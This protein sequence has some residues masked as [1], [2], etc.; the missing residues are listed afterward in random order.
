MSPDD[1]TDVEHVDDDVLT[2]LALGEPAGTPD[3]RAHVAACARCTQEVDALAEVAALARASE[4][5]VAPGPQVWDAIARDL[6]LTDRT[7]PLDEAPSG[8]PPVAEA[9]AEAPVAAVTPLRPRPNR[10]TWAFVAG[11]AAAGLVIGGTG[12]WAATRT[13]APEVLASATLEPLPGWD[14][15][16]K[17]FV[18]T[19]DGHRVL[20][21][22]LE[23]D[24]GSAGFRE[25]WLLRPDV[26]GLVS[27]GTLAGS[28]G[29][30]D[31]PAGLDLDEFSVV[32]VSEEQFDG[33]PAHSGDSIVRGPL[34]A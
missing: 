5:L 3:E 7:S 27:L 14:A 2:L 8:A 28:T 16:G 25:V 9:T 13:A 15:S 31:L 20:V 21:V 12:V 19:S 6:D 22:D 32:D 30:F 17:A 11:A 4:P 1:R 34:T 29:R 10:R 33:D 24:V 23:G 18:E 26:S